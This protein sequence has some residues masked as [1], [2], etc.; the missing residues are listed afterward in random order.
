MCVSLVYLLSASGLSWNFSCRFWRM[1]S[2]NVTVLPVSTDARSTSLSSSSFHSC[3][4]MMLICVSYF[5]DINILH[6]YWLI[7]FT[8]LSIYYLLCMEQ[9]DSENFEKLFVSFRTI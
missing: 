2:W 4:M 8:L 9:Q 7:L 6:A 5:F 1:N 3:G